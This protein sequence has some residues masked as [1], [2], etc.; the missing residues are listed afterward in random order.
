MATADHFKIND[1]VAWMAS[2]DVGGPKVEFVGT[3]TE[4][5]I[6]VVDT[7]KETIDGGFIEDKRVPAARVIPNVPQ[8]GL[9]Q[10]DMA[11]PAT[12]PEP[13]VKLSDLRRL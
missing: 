4:L 2:L 8:H 12:R 9:T 11:N 10:A 13:T 1:R 7:I 5:G 3:I 6:E